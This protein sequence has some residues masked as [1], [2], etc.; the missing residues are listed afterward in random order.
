M[1]AK[2]ERAIFAEMGW[3]RENVLWRRGSSQITL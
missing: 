1:V 2:C 3:Y